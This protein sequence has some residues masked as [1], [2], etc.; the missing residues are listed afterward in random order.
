[1]AAGKQVLHPPGRVQLAGLEEGAGAQTLLHWGVAT[2]IQVRTLSPGP[3]KETWARR[4]KRACVRPELPGSAL[5]SGASA[6]I[7]AKNAALSGD[8]LDCPPWRQ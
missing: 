7:R 3:E 8:Q 5:Q 6:R 4:R 1:M 2:P